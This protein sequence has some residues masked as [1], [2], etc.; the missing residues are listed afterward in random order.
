[1]ELDKQKNQK[2]KFQLTFTIAIFTILFIIFFIIGILIINKNIFSDKKEKNQ[3]NNQKTIINKNKKTE[4]PFIKNP[5]PP[6]DQEKLKSE[7]KEKIK[8]IIDSYEESKVISNTGF[9]ADFSNLTLDKLFN[10][11]VPAEY[12]EFHLELVRGF[13]IINQ[14]ANNEIGADKIGDGFEKINKAIEKYLEEE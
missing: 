9:W 3:T 12:K 5:L 6:V 14:S 2:I 11:I 4:N 8:E 1:M 13:S 7:Y 10:M